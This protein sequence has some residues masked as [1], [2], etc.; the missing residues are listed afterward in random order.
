MTI[1]RR[2]FMQTLGYGASGACLAA[3]LPRARAQNR[4]HPPRRFVFVVEG[5]GIEPAN[6]AS[7]ATLAAIEEHGL[8]SPYRTVGDQRQVDPNM[9]RI[10]GHAAPLNIPA[11][12]LTQASALGALGEGEHGESL[13]ADSAV[14][15][16][17]SNLITGG[18]HST[19]TGA[20]SCARAGLAEEG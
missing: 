11:D 10:Y 17:L 1:D 15:L 19:Y 7:P 12:V 5:N 2:T 18:G 3:S 14:L 9:S 6:F 13:V 16:G 8:G 4:A 20:L